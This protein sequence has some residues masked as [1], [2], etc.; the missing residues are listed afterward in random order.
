MQLDLSARTEPGFARRTFTVE[1]LELRA[2]D[3]ADTWTLEGIA[4]TVDHPYTVRDRFGEFTETIAEGAFDR[5][6]GNDQA[7]VSL[8]V[9]H[10]HSAPPMATRR[11]GTLSLTADPHLRVTAELDPARPD[12]QIVRSAIKRGEM[13]EMSVGFNDVKD[14]RVWNDDYTESTVNQLALREV[15]IVEEGA[16]DV[17]MASIRSIAA[18]IERGVDYDET[19]LRRVLARIHSMLTPD[20]AVL[21]DG[22]TVAEPAERTGLVVTDEF[23]DLFLRRV[24]A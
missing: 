7:R 22:E 9:S 4:A 19:E 14:G 18:D 10:Q 3:S 16:N 23:I 2:P 17:T 6:L 8:F 13:T 12:V 24:A 5:T 15:S 1:D 20:L 11:A 21:E